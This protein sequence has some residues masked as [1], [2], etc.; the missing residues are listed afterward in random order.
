MRY[1]SR[2]NESEIKVEELIPIIKETIIDHFKIPTREE[3]LEI[4][5]IDFEQLND[6]WNEI[7]YDSEMD[8]TLEVIGDVGIVN[9]NN[10]NRLDSNYSV[11][12]E[13]IHRSESFMVK[14]S[15]RQNV[16]IRSI[17]IRF[18]PY[19]EKLRWWSYNNEGIFILNKYNYDEV[20]D[21]IYY[22]KSLIKNN[23]GVNIGLRAAGEYSIYIYGLR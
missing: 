4:I 12:N 14:E 22:S 5:R 7:R 11:L 15:I 23:Y 17:E 6:I 20:F 19:N 1:L 10:Y 8:Y 16:H 21:F 13:A 3:F 2:I 18:R 9:I